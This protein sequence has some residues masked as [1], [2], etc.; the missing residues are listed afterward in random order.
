MTADRTL[1]RLAG[2]QIVASKISIALSLAALAKA[3][4]EMRPLTA[5]MWALA[6]AWVGF[7]AVQAFQL[8]AD[9]RAD[10]AVR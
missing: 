6:I 10:G 7:L 4:W 5:V 2:V 1:Y 9:L 8:R 3:C